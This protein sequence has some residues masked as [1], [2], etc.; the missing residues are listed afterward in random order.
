VTEA[1]LKAILSTAPGGPDTLVAREVP[2]PEPGF[3]QLRI[4]V[5]AV[6]VN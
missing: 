3:G 5:R 6:G 2:E 1:W 4:A